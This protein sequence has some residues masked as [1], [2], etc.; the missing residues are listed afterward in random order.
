M[1]DGEGLISKVFN[2]KVDLQPTWTPE[3]YCPLK[4]TLILMQSSKYKLLC[5]TLLNEICLTKKL[6]VCKGEFT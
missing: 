6:C 5:Q 4:A 2:K 3:S 1:W